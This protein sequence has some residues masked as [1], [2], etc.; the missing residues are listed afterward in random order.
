MFK[1]MIERLFT[2]TGEKI[3]KKLQ[4]VI[5][6]INSYEP[7]L[8]K[9]DNDTLFNNTVIFK[10]RLAEGESLNDILPEAFAVVRETGLR[11]MNMRHFDVQLL[12]GYVLHSGKIAEMKTGEGKT[13]VATLPLYLNALE[14]NGSHLVTVNDYLARRDAQWMAPI[15]LALGLTVGI[16]Q[17]ERSRMVVWDDKEKFTTKLV[18]ISRKDAYNCDITYGTNNE[19]GFDYLR[20]NMKYATEEYVQRILNYAIV[21]EVDSILIDE[22]RTP[23]IISGP[24]DETTDK[25]YN[26]NNIVKLLR[27]E[28]HYS[29]DE[30]RRTATLNDTGINFVEE[31]LSVGNLY[32]IA[33]VDMLHFVNNALRAHAVFKIDVDYVVQNDQIIIVDEFTGRLMQGRR[34]SD[35]LHQALEA[36]ESVTVQNENQTYA[37]ITFQNY[38]R[39]YKKLAGMTGTALTEA[40]E[41]RQI[42]DLEVAPI[43][44]HRK[45]IRIDNADV[46]Y[47]T[48]E[49]KY[50][51]VADE[52]ER[53]HTKGQPVLVGTVSIEKSEVISHYLTKRKIKHEVLNAKNHEREAEIVSLAGQ[54]GAVTIAT[55]MAG[56]GTDIKLGE[57]VNELGGLYILGTERHESRRIDNQLRGRSGRQGDNG[58]STFFLSM[59]DDLLR[60]F[61][62]EKISAIMNRLGMKEGEEIQSPLI[63]RSIE[64]AQKHVESM[65]FEV[66]KHLLEYDDVSNAQRKVVYDLRRDILSGKDIDILLNE[67]ASDTVMALLEDFITEQ[68]NYDEAQEIFLRIFDIPVDLKSAHIKHLDVTSKELMDLFNKKLEERKVEFKG[69]FNDFAKY[70]LISVLDTR[71]KE[72]LLQMDHL[73]DSVGLRGYGQKDPLIEYK[74][75]AYGIFVAMV[76]KVHR[77]VIELVMKV[78]IKEQSPEEAAAENARKLRALQ[79][80][81]S[82]KLAEG[83]SEQARVASS[84]RKPRPVKRAAP[85]V[86]R[87]DPCPCGS[88][89]KYKNCHGSADASAE[90]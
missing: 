9:L 64:N 45:M 75:E 53:L 57:G 77:E 4:P 59:Q 19:F 90:S 23:L 31:R 30:K 52:I 83:R 80:A 29:V 67:Y 15:Y 25:Y 38:F 36:K 86:G 69:H 20:D 5:D 82:K 12:G 22:A 87:N 50:K 47:R 73:R 33:N 37:S 71:W 42:Y 72:H 8:Q 60:I 1:E 81:N 7:E 41:F 61:G 43:P 51:A 6:K 39:M 89:K 54:K 27:K 28:D 35:G 63:S 17:H 74:R 76:D 62:A 40:N 10:K 3:L 55:N 16:I 14:G 84:E 66:R 46:I 44:T 21:D 13:L 32:D 70:I 88:G 48:A 79:D 65:H 85:K 26:V 58:E 56:R 2:P 34:Y 24:T 68:P 18:D 49:E 78:Q 11:V